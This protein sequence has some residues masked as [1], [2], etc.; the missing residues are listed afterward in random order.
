MSD[1]EVVGCSMVVGSEVAAW[2]AELLVEPQHR[3]QGE[4]TLGDS[5]P[6]PG[7]AAP[8][9]LFQAEL[10]FERVDDALDA[11]ADPAQVP[12]TDRFVA[13]VGP[14]KDRLQLADLAFEPGTGKAL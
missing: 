10:A 13:T 12:M 2:P 8:A 6:D 7:N 9:V 3:G 11:L 1:S 5:D 4:Q 14:D